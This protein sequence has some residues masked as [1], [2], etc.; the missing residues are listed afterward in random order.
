M[1]NAKKYSIQKDKSMYFN[2]SKTLIWKL[3]NACICTSYLVNMYIKQYTYKTSQIKYRNN[4]K[5]VHQN[6]NL[7]VSCSYVP[8]RVDKHLRKNKT[9]ETGYKED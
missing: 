7:L 5:M 8:H 2:F 4:I 6:L 3:T 9:I 1:R